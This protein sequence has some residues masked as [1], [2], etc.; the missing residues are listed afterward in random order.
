MVCTMD[1]MS[2]EF[3]EAFSTIKDM[4]EDARNNP[5]LSE[6]AEQI[7]L[8][9]INLDTLCHSNLEALLYQAIRLLKLKDVEIQTQKEIINMQKA[10]ISDR[11]KLDKNI[12][13]HKNK[14]S[15]YR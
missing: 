11:G 12:S 5:A 7:N 4:I 14:G 15:N 2:I 6:L 13:E 9:E 3:E 8:L 10:L 1:Y